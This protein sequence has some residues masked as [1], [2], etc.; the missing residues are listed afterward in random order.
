MHVG[1]KIKTLKLFFSHVFGDQWR[2]TPW[3]R[4]GI[5]RSLQQFSFQYVLSSLSYWLFSATWGRK[6]V[7][8]H[9]IGENSLS[10]P[11][12]I[13]EVIITLLKG[14]VHENM[15]SAPYNVF[16][17]PGR[18]RGRR[19]QWRM[20]FYR[21]PRSTKTATSPKFMYLKNTQSDYTF[22]N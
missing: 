1:T 7:V 9:S 8:T 13:V 15:I 5:W 18:T 22:H 19:D 11:A 6:A 17:F 16:R 21:G 4:I 20:R 3:T 2:P 12:V 14:K 10:T